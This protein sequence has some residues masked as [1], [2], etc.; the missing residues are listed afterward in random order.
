MPYLIALAAILIDQYTKALAVLKL[1]AASAPVIQNVFHFTY[2][3]NTGA[4]FGIFKNGNSVFTAV[5]SIVLIGIV[6]ALVIIK[7]P[8]RILKISAGLILGGAAGNLIDRIFRGFVVDFFDFR[9]IN[10]A[11]FN[12]ADSCV[13]VGAVLLCVYL[14]FLEQKK[15]ADDEKA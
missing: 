7:P 3:E 9:L 11:V 14:L 4:A 10:F 12:V 13:T 15:V 2:V 8:Q 6:V 1:Q 5:I